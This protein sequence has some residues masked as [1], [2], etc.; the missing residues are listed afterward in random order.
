MTE[1]PLGYINGMMKIAITYDEC[2]DYPETC[3]DINNIIFKIEMA[4]AT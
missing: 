2:T 4:I 1:T 3:D